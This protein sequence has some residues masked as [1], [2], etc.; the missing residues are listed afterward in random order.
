MAAIFWGSDKLLRQM[1]EA[2]IS[3]AQASAIAKGM[4]TMVIQNFDAL[5][6]SDY[7]D[8]WF[9][10]FESRLGRELDQRFAEQDHHIQLG[11]AQ[12]EAR[13]A[14]INMML[15]VIMAGIALPTIQSLVSLLGR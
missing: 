3:R 9:G 5:V 10:E 14:L 2:G 7:L 6:T 15:A 13:S 11:F 1:E 8:A 12:V 4:A